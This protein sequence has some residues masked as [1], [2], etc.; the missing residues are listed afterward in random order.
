MET[1]RTSGDACA[2]KVL[3]GGEA[4]V[5]IQKKMMTQKQPPPPRL[6]LRVGRKP[7]EFS[8]YDLTLYK[9]SDRMEA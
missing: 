5:I 3:D 2:A 9:H 7:Q 8:Q 1:N 6:V 4:K